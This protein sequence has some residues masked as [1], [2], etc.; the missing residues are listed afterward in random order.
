MSLVSHFVRLSSQEAQTPNGVWAWARRLSTAL[1]R[2]RWF[3]LMDVP[4]SDKPFYIMRVKAD[5]MGV[6]LAPEELGLAG[7]DL[8]GLANQ[9]IRVKPTEDGYVISKEVLHS[10]LGVALVAGKIIR[11]N[12]AADGFVY[13]YEVMESLRTISLAGKAGK[14]VVVNAAETGFDIAP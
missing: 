5:G 7:E 8:T 1:E 14:A 3:D 11:T 10:L 4:L 13:D 12:A 6:E 2:W 9:V